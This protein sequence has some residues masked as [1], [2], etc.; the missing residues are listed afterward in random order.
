MKN[1]TFINNKFVKHSNAKISIEDRG[2]LFADS[3]YELISVF[4]NNAIDTDQHLDRLESSLKEIKIKYKFNKNKFKKV[5]EKLIKVNNVING[6]IYIQITRGVAERKH[7]FPK[8]YS[9]TTIVFTKHLN[10]DKKIYKN[11]VKIITIEDLRWLRRDIKSTSLLPNILSKQI[12]VE[13]NAFESWLIDDGVITE[14]SSSN[15][16]IITNSNTII[17]HPANNKILKGVTRETLIKI[18]KKNN[19]K[20]KEKP[21]NLIEAK[22]AKEAFLTSST[23]S[24]LPVVKIDNYNVS[25]GK[26]GDVTKKIINLYND[27]IFKNKSSISKE[28][29]IA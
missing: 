16:W 27:Y 1:I 20:I 24:V 11:G 2:F 12:A 5:F 4:D 25:N 13:K 17:T 9:P 15:A 21:F 26:P 6:Y 19:F 29:K 14:G 18:L 7:E 28:L 3:I 23:L 10:I 22:N 8:N